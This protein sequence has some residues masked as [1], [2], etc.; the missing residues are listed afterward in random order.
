MKQVTKTARDVHFMAKKSIILTVF[1]SILPF[2]LHASEKQHNLGY[3][4][5]MKLLINEARENSVNSPF[6]AMIIDNRSGAI[7]CKGLNLGTP[8]PIDHGELEAIASCSDRYGANIRWR[9]TTLITT[10]EPCPMCQGA[11]SWSNISKVVYGTSIPFLIRN[12]WKQIDIRSY[13]IA[14]RSRFNR[15]TIVGGVLEKQT[16]ALFI[17]TPKKGSHLDT[18]QSH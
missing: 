2:Q 5:Y 8:N 18:S 3:E 15:T 6:A 17:R 7:L 13:E 16:N 14:K 11:I 10:A 1:L 4:Y 12:G 9:N